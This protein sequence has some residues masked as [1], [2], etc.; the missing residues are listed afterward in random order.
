MPTTSKC[1]K[2]KEKNPFTKRCVNK[3]KDGYRRRIEKKTKKFDCV[4][5]KKISRSLKSPDKLSERFKNSLY[6]KL[7]IEKNTN[8]LVIGDVQSGKTDV[9]IGYCY[10]SKKLGKKVLYLVRNMKSDAE[11]LQERFQ[12]ISEEFP[13]QVKRINEYG[14]EKQIRKMESLEGKN[15]DVIICLMNP[16]S[17]S[18]FEILVEK[19]GFEFNICVDESDLISGD[20]GSGERS[21]K[22]LRDNSK[23]FNFLA[24]TA[25]PIATV[26]NMNINYFYKLPR[27]IHYTHIEHPRIQWLTLFP[28]SSKNYELD[29]ENMNQIL[30]SGL[31][32]KICI[33]LMVTTIENKKQTD[34]VQSLLTTNPKY[35]GI[36]YN[37]NSVSILRNV[38]GMIRNVKDNKTINEAI[39]NAVAL[40]KH[41]VILA[42]KKADRGISFVSKDYKYHLTDLYLRSDENPTIHCESLIQR[43]RILGKYTHKEPDKGE[44]SIFKSDKESKL[45]IWSTEELKDEVLNCYHLIQKLTNKLVDFTEKGSKIVTKADINRILEELKFKKGELP[46]IDL[47][48]KRHN[49]NIIQEKAAKVKNE[50]I[51]Y[52]KEADGYCLKHPTGNFCV[53]PSQLKC[54]ED[55][56]LI[57][58]ELGKFLEKDFSSSSIK[59]HL[60]GYFYED[61][62]LPENKDEI[63]NLRQEYL[64]TKDTVDLRRYE[65]SVKRNCKQ[66]VEQRF[67]SDDLKNYSSQLKQ[68]IERKGLSLSNFSFKSYIGDRITKSKLAFKNRR[69]QIEKYLETN[70]TEEYEISVGKPFDF[71]IG[72]ILDDMKIPLVFTFFI[73][74]NFKYDGL[75]Y[76]SGIKENDI[77]YWQNLQGITYVNFINNK[78]LLKDYINKG[79]FVFQ[80]KEEE[81]S[82]SSSSLSNSVSPKPYDPLRT[83]LKNI[84]SRLFKISSNDFNKDKGNGKLLKEYHELR[85]RYWLKESDPINKI[86][87][88]FERDY[89]HIKTYKIADMG[90]GNA[91]LARHFGKRLN[92]SSFDHFKIN[93]FV[94]PVN[95]KN[96]GQKDKEFNYILYCLSIS[97]GNSKEINDYLDESFRICKEDGVINIICTE[98]DKDNLEDILRS[99]YHDRITKIEPPLSFAGKYFSITCVGVNSIHYGV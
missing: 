61:T 87:E 9:M 62:L 42:G 57:I 39:S 38:H 30:R 86:I 14:S 32:K 51:K 93:D 21:L 19:F 34:I 75:E 46:K 27:N 37:Q 53:N 80:K 5:T 71:S 15:A 18:K 99:D 1:P 26:F 16:T 31:Q 29:L 91:K 81:Q 11:Q 92:I 45:C 70:K 73:P 95:M 22:R 17:I 56:D 78:N 40:G 3:C 25:T 7:K 36:I 48:K 47:V 12:K 88:I 94:T 2:G 55:R 65:S 74:Y 63:E 54:E 82:L 98:G 43:L 4:K 59:K 6:D 97:W 66:F 52:D 44:N 60:Y 79:E 41:I 76:D 49:E 67:L 13:I 20:D 50:I 84:H 35:L 83:R 64:R 24:V 72:K 10:K 96:T 28:T 8:S 68:F 69:T 85:D 58:E 77:V 90:C 89:Q 33:A 23:R